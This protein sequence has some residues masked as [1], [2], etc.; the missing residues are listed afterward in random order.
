VVQPPSLQNL[1]A[2]EDPMRF[3]KLRVTVKHSKGKLCLLIE[4]F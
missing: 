1:R 4:W 2:K 3:Y